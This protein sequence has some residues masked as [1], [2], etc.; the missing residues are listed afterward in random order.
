MPD[1][2]ITEV[3][4]SNL[5]QHSAVK[6]WRGLQPGQADPQRIEILNEKKKS[7]AYRLESVGLGGT[8][9]VAKRCLRVTGLIERTIYEQVLPHLPVASLHYYGFGDEDDNSCWLFLEDVGKERFSPLVEEQRTLA[10]RWLGI[11]HT[12]AAHIAAANKL[13][14]GGPRRYLGHLRFARDA[15]L[16][17]RTN[18]VLRAGDV[19]G[20]EDILK[21]FDFL[22]K[23]WN[24]VERWCEGMSQTLVHG[25]FRPKN[26]YVRTD[27]TGTAFFP[28]DWETAGWGVP[29]ADLAPMRGLPLAN[30]VDI[31]AYW[32]AVR[33][34]WPFLDI[35]TIER[36]VNIGRIFRR[37]AAV[38]WAST[39]LGFETNEFLWWAV[40]SM[41]IYHEELSDAIRMAQLD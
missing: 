4:Q 33:D 21:Q 3:S 25:D 30:Q 31:V 16:R 12:S 13:P 29:A 20:F 2:A 37:L 35:P 6:A 7:A 10:A 41:K 17:H 8:A 22:E 27:H 14:D 32:S 40:E 5:L 28:L 19:T 24:R 1:Q 26:I 34:S 18:P 36:L 15:I 23:R 9:V 38:S 11:V 39:S